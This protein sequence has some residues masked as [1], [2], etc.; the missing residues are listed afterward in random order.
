MSYWLLEAEIV[1]IGFGIRMSD[2]VTCSTLSGARCN[3]KLQI[4]R[5]LHVGSWQLSLL[6]GKR[7]IGMAKRGNGGVSNSLNPEIN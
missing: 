6:S 4:D 1:G 3:L 2:Y 5:R 7:F